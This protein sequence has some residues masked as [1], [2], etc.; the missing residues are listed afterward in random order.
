MP[1]A[2]DDIAVQNDR[3]VSDYLV[4]YNK[5]SLAETVRFLIEERLPGSSI[6]LTDIAA[7][8][9]MSPRTLNRQL[10][11]EKTSY[12]DVL[13]KV[14]KDKARAYFEQDRSSILEIAVNL[15]YADSSNFSRAFKRWFGVPPSVYR[16]SSIKK[17]S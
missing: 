3:I 17:P 15:G 12:R 7:D 16:N 2:N 10:Q 8:L 14:R 4:R 9:G 5:R 13:D 6:E 1:S 11:K